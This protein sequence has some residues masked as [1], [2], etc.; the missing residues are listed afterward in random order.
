M[1]GRWMKGAGG[2][3][4]NVLRTNKVIDKDRVDLVDLVL[5]QFF[6]LLAPHLG[7]YDLLSSR[8][9]TGLLFCIFR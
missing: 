8:R 4:L 3:V 2:A 6:Y 5:R 9:Y 7:H 1:A